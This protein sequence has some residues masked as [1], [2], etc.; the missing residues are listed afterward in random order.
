MSRSQAAPAIALLAIAVVA[1]WWWGQRAPEPAPGTAA[2]HDHPS[3]STA[4]NTLTVHVAGWVQRPGLVELPEGSRVADAVAAA[5][6]LLPSANAESVNLAAEVGDGEQIVVPGPYHAAASGSAAVDDG[7]VH[8]NRATAAELEAL[9]GV[10][11]VLAERIVAYRDEKGPFGT[12]EDL[13]DVP[14]IGEAKLSSFR[15]LL[16]IP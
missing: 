10:G 6:G 12:L 7:K 2:S 4:A 16:A 11:P 3:S 14:G 1:G 9:P 15:D 8:L 13:L 5:G